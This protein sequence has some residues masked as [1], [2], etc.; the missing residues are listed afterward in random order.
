MI[1]ITYD[2]TDISIPPLLP[3]FIVEILQRFRPHYLL[4]FNS[5]DPITPYSYIVLT[6]I[7]PTL[8]SS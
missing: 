2:S 8:T 7:T 1:Q 6:P 3:Q 4:L 5:L